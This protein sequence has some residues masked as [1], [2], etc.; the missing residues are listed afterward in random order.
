MM[1]KTF[2]EDLILVA[3]LRGP[4]KG[5]TVSEPLLVAGSDRLAKEAQE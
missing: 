3:L 4:R 5:M 2:P 1:T